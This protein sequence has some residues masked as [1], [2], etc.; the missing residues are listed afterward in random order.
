[1]LTVD[2]GQSCDERVAERVDSRLSRVRVATNVLAVE[3]HAHLV[4]RHRSRGLAYE[5][6]HLPIHIIVR[7]HMSVCMKRR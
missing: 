2:L 3:V 6:R 5:L 4:V 1:M 7:K